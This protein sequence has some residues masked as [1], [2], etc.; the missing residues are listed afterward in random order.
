MDLLYI[1]VCSIKTHSYLLSYGHLYDL[2]YGR[3]SVN[4]KN[5]PKS[6]SDRNVAKCAEKV[7]FLDF[8]RFFSIP[9]IDFFTAGIFYFTAI[10]LEIK[11]K[12]DLLAFFH[13]EKCF[14]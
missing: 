1:R 4:K 3:K 12:K 6:L 2:H 10:H 7:L 14:L 11:W 5:R 13:M 9:V 8:Y